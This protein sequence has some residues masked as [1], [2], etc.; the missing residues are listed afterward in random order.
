MSATQKWTAQA[1][2]EGKISENQKGPGQLQVFYVDFVGVDGEVKDGAYWRRKVGNAPNVGE[3][4]YGTIKEGDYGPRFYQERQEGSPPTPSP[5]KGREWKSESDFDPERTARI[6]RSHA[7]E[8]ALRAIA[9][10]GVRD[11]NA[12]LKGPLITWTD[13]FEADVNR[14]AKAARGGGEAPGTESV[15]APPPS[16]K[17]EQEAFLN[18][19]D[20]AGVPAPA[21]RVIGDYVN[22]EFTDQQRRSAT[23]SLLNIDTQGDA[24][25]KLWDLTEKAFGEPL[26]T[27]EED[28]SSIPF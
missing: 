4:Y 21:G 5:S 17:D 6:G 25:K 28:D 2:R 20:N 9:L 13:F 18:A 8:M 10:Y 24:R 19:L 23:Q 15:P 14:A 12:D 11:G 27:V 22:Q 1:V 16:Q 26:P 3:S 7:Q